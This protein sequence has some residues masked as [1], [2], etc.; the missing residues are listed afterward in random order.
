MTGKKH[1]YSFL[2]VCFLFRIILVIVIL[3]CR[4]K[5]ISEEKQQGYLEEKMLRQEDKKGLRPLKA[6]LQPNLHKIY[7]TDHNF[8][9][10]C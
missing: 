3:T 8:E 10:I 1:S 9:D 7:S 2:L 6:W 5:V 4:G